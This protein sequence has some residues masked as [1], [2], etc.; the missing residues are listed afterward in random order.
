MSTSFPRSRGSLSRDSSRT[1]LLGIAFAVALAAAWITWAFAAR[2]NRYEIS[3]SARLEVA[4]SAYPVQARVAGRLVATYLELGREVRAGDVLLELESDS[5][6][7]ALDEEKTRISVLA[8]QIAALQAQLDLQQEGSATERAVMQVSLDEARARYREAEALARLAEQNAERSSR[9][10]AEGLISEAE[11]QRAT[12]E[13]T[14]KRAAAENLRN[15]VARVEP[16]Q[17]IRETDRE[18][19][20]KQVLTDLARLHAQASTSAATISRLEYDMERRRIRAPIAGRL[21][22]CA[23][24]RPGAWL[25]E[26]EKVGLIIPVGD[27]AVIAEFSPDTALGRLHEGQN[28]T[29]RLEGFPWAQYGTIAARVTR[30]ADEIRDSNVRVELAVTRNSKSPIPLQHGLPGAVEVEVERISPA[31]LLLRTAG[32]LL[33]K[34]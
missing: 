7:L 30:V 6:R 28:A 24:L 3:R 34:R 17:E 2:I 9:M 20:R 4:R 12:A 22:E 14:S 13:S 19:K 18:V 32:G 10:K 31:A 5:Q 33:A 16:E 21:G 11:Y 1:Y 8:P 25:S 29:V 26:G 15:A 23:A 27:L